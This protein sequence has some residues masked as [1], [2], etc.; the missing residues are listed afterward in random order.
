MK[1]IR[2]I[3]L[4]KEKT[5]VGGWAE[6]NINDGEEMQDEKTQHHYIILCTGRRRIRNDVP[7]ALNESLC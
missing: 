2:I 6:R 5:L 3:Y 1:K 7:K 4:L